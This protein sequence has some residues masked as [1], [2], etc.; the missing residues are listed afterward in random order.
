MTGANL[1]TIPMRTLATQV[2]TIE[3]RNVIVEFIQK[4]GA[5][6]ANYSATNHGDITT[7]FTQLEFLLG[8]PAFWAAIDQFPND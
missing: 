7:V 6:R 4:M 5:G 3:N 8:A 2:T 1:P